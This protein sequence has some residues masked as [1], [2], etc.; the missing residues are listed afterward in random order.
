V[1]ES[2][3]G[4]ALRPISIYIHVP[5]C[6]V[7]CAYCDFNSYANAEEQIPGWEAALLE[8]LRRWATVVRGRPVAT[9]FLG[10]GT[11]SL[12]E[13]ASVERIMDVIATDYA[14]VS[15]AEITMEAN[16][17]STRLERLRGYRRAGVNRLSIGVQ[18][19]D[20]DELKFLDRLHDVDGARNAVGDARSAGFENI[21]VDLIYGLPNQSLAAWQTSL[22]G[23]VGW[24]PDHISCYALTVEEDTPLA[25]RVASG[26]V[27]EIDPDTAADMTDWTEER[28]AAAGYGQ[29]E[30][31]N[32]A[33]PGRECQHNLV[34]WRHREY[35]GLGPGAHGFVDG[36]RYSVDRSPGR[37]IDALKKPGGAHGLPSPAVV[38]VER[39]DDETAALDAAVM[40]LRLNAG[41]VAAEMAQTFGEAWERFAKALEWAKGAELLE[42]SDD[43]LRLT[44]RGRRLANEVFVRLMEPSLI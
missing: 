6:T 29:Y 31:S 4:P 12:L 34:Y 18:S 36:V 24:E 8:E 2:P 30:I 23:A 38:T 25:S 3:S 35:V 19:L 44:R 5:F 17:E 9:V 40:G 37:Y 39:V 7:K 14:L 32:Y 42:E 26:S 20:P 22:Q 41:I 11:P 15:D 10:G 13:V 16:P 21:S 27:R 1:R 33:Q 28:L 43:R